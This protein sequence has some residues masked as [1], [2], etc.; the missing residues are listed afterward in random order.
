VEEEVVLEYRIVTLV[1]PTVLSFLRRHWLIEN[2]EGQE[3][4]GV[5]Y[6]L[7]YP[8]RSA[9]C[10]GN[11]PIQRGQILRFLT[12]SLRTH[13]LVRTVPVQYQYSSTST[14]LHGSHTYRTRVLEQRGTG[15]GAVCSN[16]LAG[17]R[18]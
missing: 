16:T 13:I 12:Q 11:T 10:F 2:S 7:P 5:L 18:R 9:G 8:Y 15:Y 3:Q 17:R 14:S 1:V 6:S 4:E